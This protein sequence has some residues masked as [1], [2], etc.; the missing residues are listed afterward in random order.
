MNPIVALKKILE[1]IVESIESAGPDGISEGMI[2]SA[3]TT[4]GCTPSQ[5]DAIR[6]ALVATGRVRR[7]GSLLF[8]ARAE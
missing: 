7:D 2:Y 5:W 4:Q 1:S 3:L 6:N 8:A